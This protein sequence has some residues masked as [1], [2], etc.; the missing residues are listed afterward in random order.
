MWRLLRLSI[1]VCMKRCHRTFEKR[2]TFEDWFNLTGLACLAG[3]SLGGGVGTFL[4][5]DGGNLLVCLVG[6]LIVP[7]VC[8]PVVFI[9]LTAAALASLCKP[10]R[11]VATEWGYQIHYLIG[12]ADIKRGTRKGRIHSRGVVA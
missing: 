8:S 1:F 2:W 7:L 10:R 11:I 5:V 9:A 4:F 3:I 12:R 6:W